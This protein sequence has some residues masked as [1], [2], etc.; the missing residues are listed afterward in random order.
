MGSFCCSFRTADELEGPR[1]RVRDSR[2]RTCLPFHAFMTNLPTA[3]PHEHTPAEERRIRE[4]ALDETIADTF[5][6]SH[7]PS[8]LPNPDQ[9][10]AEGS[11]VEP[12][13]KPR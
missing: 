12:S 4:A 3:D 7:P 11:G 13:E 2:S 8:S 10:D 1:G 9:H 6:A 5:P